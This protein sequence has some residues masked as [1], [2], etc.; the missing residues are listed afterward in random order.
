M[1]RLLLIFRLVAADLRR[2]PGEAVMLLV[3]IMAA[4]TTL[5]LGLVLHG[6]TNHPYEQTRVATAAPD[7]VGL[8]TIPSRLGAR[9]PVVE[10]LQAETA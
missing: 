5:T 9:R 6:E 4:T 10:I 1:G 3:V 8:T 7:V 2:R